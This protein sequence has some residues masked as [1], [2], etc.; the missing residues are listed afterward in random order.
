MRTTDPK[1]SSHE[2]TRRGGSLFARLRAFFA[3]LLFG[4][5]ALSSHASTASETNPERD[6]IELRIERA[7]EKLRAE[8]VEAADDKEGILEAIAQ[9]M[10]WGN[11]P[12][13]WQNWNNWRNW[14]NWPNY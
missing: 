4:S 8:A 12:N 9:W 10:N 7:A 2:R 3:G 5:A 1:F 14:P 11:W 6:G 13:G